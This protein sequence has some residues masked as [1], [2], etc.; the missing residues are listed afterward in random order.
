MR[1]TGQEKAVWGRRVPVI[2]LL[3]VTGLAVL[4]SPAEAI[5]AFARKYQFSCS[6]CHSPV[7]R[8]KPFGEAFAA[9]G[10]RLEDPSQE[11]TRATYDTGDP[12]LRLMRELPLAFRLDGYGS[13]K[14]NAAATTDNEWPW[15]FKIL[16]GGQIHERI[17]YYM[18]FILEK[19]GVQGLEDAWLQ[20]SLPLKTPINVTA[21]QF[22]ICD[23]LFKREVRLERFDYDIFSTRVGASPISLTYDRGIIASWSFPGEV[24]SVV[25]VVNGNGI[26]EAD[27]DSNFDEDGLKNVSL[28]LARTFD[29]VRLGAFTYW[30]KTRG[31]DGDNRTYY[32]GPDVVVTFSD[33]VQLNMQYLERRDDNPLFAAAPGAEWKTRGGFAELVFLPRGADGRHSLA[34]LYNKVDSDDPNARRETVSGTLGY[35]LARNVR[36]VVE[37]GRDV[38]RKAARLSIGVVS[39]F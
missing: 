4:P 11:P 39:A 2:A 37:V 10:F 15:A 12:M 25:Q 22:Q 18:Y 29:R 27:D 30:G 13:W 28:R 21:G 17:S 1:I 36:A 14:E 23:P 35:L 5:P 3:A 31:T 8:L 9:R 19:G 34:A 6:T 26:H 7:P 20:F 33:R 32:L 24:E 16:S 38:E